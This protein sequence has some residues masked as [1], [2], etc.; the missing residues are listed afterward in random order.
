MFMVIVYYP[1]NDYMSLNKKI[2][3]F[4]YLILFISD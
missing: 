3:K 2:T 1:L 4:A